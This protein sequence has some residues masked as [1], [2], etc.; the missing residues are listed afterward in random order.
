MYPFRRI[1]AATFVAISL[2]LGLSAHAPVTAAPTTTVRQFTRGEWQINAVRSQT[3]ASANATHAVPPD[4]YLDLGSWG[5]YVVSQLTSKGAQLVVTTATETGF[6]TRFVTDGS[7]ND[8]SARLSP[9]VQQLV[10]ESDRTGNQDLFR[11]SVVGT[12]LTQLTS[13]SANEIQPVWSPN[14]ARMAFASDRDGNWNIYTMNADGSNQTRITDDAAPDVMPAWSPDGSTLAW[15]RLGSNTTSA[16]WLMN[17]DGSNQRAITP[18]LRYLGHPVWSAEGTRL[19]F[20]YDADGNALNELAVVNTDSS[21]L[22]GVHVTTSG[23]PGDQF[24]YAAAGWAS[25]DEY[26][27]LDAESYHTENG[28]TTLTRIFT[29]SVPSTGGGISSFGGMLNTFAIDLGSTDRTPPVTIIKA[30]PAETRGSSVAFRWYGQAQ[31]SNDKTTFDLQYRV[32]DA[33]EW[34]NWLTR[35][36]EYGS[37]AVYSGT[38]GTTVEFRIRGRDLAGNREAWH[39]ASGGSRTTFYTWRMAGAITDNRGQP[40]GDAN[41][42]FAPQAIGT[43]AYTGGDGVFRAL[44]KQTG[45]YALTPNAPGYFA[46][47]ASTRQIDRDQGFSTYLP[48]KDSVI[49]NGTFEAPGSSLTNW[50]PGGNLPSSPV[51]TARTGVRAAQLGQQCPLP[52]LTTP[53]IVPTNPPTRS[54]PMLLDLALDDTATAYLVTLTA[55]NTTFFSGARLDLFERT[56]DGTWLSPVTLGNGGPAKIAVDSKRTVHVVWIGKEYRLLYRQRP[57]GGTWSEPVDIGSTASK[58]QLF[59]DRTDAIYLMTDQGS[60]RVRTPDGVWQP[61]RSTPGVVT[62][63]AVRPD[64]TLQVVWKKGLDDQNDVAGYT[65]RLQPD[66]NFSP[67]QGFGMSIPNGDDPQVVVD[68]TGRTQVV[69]SGNGSLYESEQLADR[70]FTA[71]NEL[72]QGGNVR[73]AL[74]GGTLYATT[75]FQQNA[76]PMNGSYLR[77]RSASGE[78]SAPIRLYSI[79]GSAPLLV[80]NQ[81]GQVGI[82]YVGPM[83]SPSSGNRVYV[84][85]ARSD[86]IAGDATLTQR[87][88]IPATLHQPTLAFDFLLTGTV[89][90]NGSQLIT[91]I[92]AAGATTSVFTSTVSGNWAHAG[93]G[94]EQWAGQT[95]AVTIA[96]HQASG[97]PPASA[98]I[99][100][101]SLGSWQTPVVESLSVQQVEAMQTSVITITGNNFI[102]TPTVSL[103]SIALTNIVQVN[104]TML[105]ATIP[106]TVPAGRYQL[107]VVNPAGQRALG[108]TLLVGRANFLPLTQR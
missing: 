65:A 37:S 42:D 52:C 30:I 93:I 45:S 40:I 31:G 91:T 98:I 104:A 14:G 33:P 99:D 9:N 21:V 106:A 92:T 26:L 13:T 49:Q 94:L 38:L 64:N 24:A 15:V 88:I 46:P 20:D 79:V 75:V 80:T 90:A 50:S 16:I 5:I 73:L 29:G 2:L 1:I 97:A 55:D 51:A 77:T 25:G 19:A 78:W 41:V 35:F 69:W 22:Q 105:Q 103:G 4:Q 107:I 86:T 67:A 7:A 43:A 74:A 85:M 101:V 89:P 32:D 44:I 39:S 23:L 95:V 71:P 8:T 56:A 83:S 68:A 102:A 82:I 53:E 63:A 81:R 60:Y 36:R 10:F 66:G 18:Q 84:Q 76:S 12:G 96:V 6:S 17:A 11:M 87:M 48:P 28:K 58:I 62:G 54:E 3:Y 34:Q 108:P 61:A 70:T 47:P 59:A 100:D 57:V 72:P 27:I